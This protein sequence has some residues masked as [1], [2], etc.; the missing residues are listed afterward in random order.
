MSSAADVLAEARS[1]L[2]NVGG[3]EFK[4]WYAGVSGD[5]EMTASWVPWCAIFVSYVFD[6]CGQ[7]VPGLPTAS[8][9]TIV[10]GAS[11]AGRTVDVRS[12]QPGDIVIF[13]WHTSA[14]G[15]DHVGIVELNLGSSLQTV[16]GNTSNAVN[17]RSRDWE[18]V[19]YVIRPAYDAASD[20]PTPVTPSQPTGGHLD[21]AED[22]LLLDGYLGPL[23]VKYVQMRLRSAGWY[24]RSID[25]DFGYYTRFALQ[26]YLRYNC[27]TYQRN[28]DGDFGTYSVKALQQHLLDVGCYWDAH[29]D[30]LVDGDWGALTTVGLQRA[31]DAGVL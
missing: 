30:C 29:G 28:C 21:P 13:D 5:S 1:H 31:I 3:A 15:H 18:N 24:M 4:R 7:D 20:E 25:G 27:G 26:K 16:E 8:C 17:R 19:Q 6:R 10:N 23:T 14:S 11:R 9:G 12:A 22:P 2:G